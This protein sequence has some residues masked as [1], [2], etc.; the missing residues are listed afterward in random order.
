M[1]GAHRLVEGPVRRGDYTPV[2]PL[3]CS[4]PPGGRSRRPGARAGASLR[5]G[6]MSSATSSRKTVPAEDSASSPSRS[7]AARERAPAVAEQLPVEQLGAE[8]GAVDRDECAPRPRALLVDRPRDQPSRCPPPSMT[9][10]N[11]EPAMRG[12]RSRSSR[13]APLSPTSRATPRGGTPASRHII[14]PGRGRRRARPAPRRSGR[15]PRRAATARR[16]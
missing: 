3:C 10:G 9:T 7:P 14:R 15:G 13:I 6:G 2:D 16:R 1:A 4:F 12:I 5:R 8:Q 11:G